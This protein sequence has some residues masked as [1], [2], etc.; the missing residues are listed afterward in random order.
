MTKEDVRQ[1]FDEDVDLDDYDLGG[2]E[3]NDEDYQSIADAVN[4]GDMEISEAVDAY[5]DGVREILEA[6]EAG[7]DGGVD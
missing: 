1:Y 4:E 6:E 5:L 2:C 3:I 7:V